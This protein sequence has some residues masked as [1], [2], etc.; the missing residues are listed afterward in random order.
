[1]IV[2]IMRNAMVAGSGAGLKEV[3]VTVSGPTASVL[4]LA[5]R[6]GEN[7]RQRHKVRQ[8]ANLLPI[9]SLLSQQNSLISSLARSIKKALG[10][11]TRLR[12]CTLSQVLQVI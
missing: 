6:F 9:A 3:I 5:L 12:F 2:P 7:I 11:S 1:M 8:H 10:R 4:W